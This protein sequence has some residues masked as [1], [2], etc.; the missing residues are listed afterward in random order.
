LPNHPNYGH[1]CKRVNGLKADFNSSGIRTDVD[2]E[3]DI[4]VAIGNTGIKV[5]TGASECLTSGMH[6]T[7]EKKVISKFMLL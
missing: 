2:D 7:R 5:T 3:D 1:L 6:K 4:I